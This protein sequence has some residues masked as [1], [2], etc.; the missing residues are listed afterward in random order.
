M[1]F[2]TILNGDWQQSVDYNAALS[3][4]QDVIDK[5]AAFAYFATD[6]QLHTWL[7]HL[8]LDDYRSA[9]TLMDSVINKQME[10][11]ERQWLWRR[12]RYLAEIEEDDLPF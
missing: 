11:I 8:F 12:E 10:E 9:I 2:E 7:R 1:N 3:L 5:S 6:N 4:K